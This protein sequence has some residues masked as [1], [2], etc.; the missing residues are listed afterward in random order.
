MT[1]KMLLIWRNF[2][3]SGHTVS[4]ENNYF[5]LFCRNTTAVKLPQYFVACFEVLSMF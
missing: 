5:T 1:F 4:A 3:Q 2:A